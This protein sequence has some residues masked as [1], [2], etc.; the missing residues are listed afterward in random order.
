MIVVYL[1]R[2][3]EHLVSFLGYFDELTIS[4]VII[5]AFL[6]LVGAS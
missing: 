4:D 6:V 1:C 3:L 2:S 5:S